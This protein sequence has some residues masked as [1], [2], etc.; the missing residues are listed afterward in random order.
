MILDDVHLICPRIGGSGGADQL[1][2]TLLALLDGLGRSKKDGVEAHLDS[3]S[4]G[5]V[6]LAITTD[7][8]LLDPA[9]R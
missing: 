3:A 9:L 8:I 7:P 1:A 4:C 5:V 6:V 2:G